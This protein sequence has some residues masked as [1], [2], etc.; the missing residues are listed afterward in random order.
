M[1]PWTP[2]LSS[3]MQPANL[4]VK[5]MNP[6]GPNPCMTRANSSVPAPTNGSVTTL[7]VPS[8]D[9]DLLTVLKPGIAPPVCSRVPLQPVAAFNDAVCDRLKSMHTTGPLTEVFDEDH[10][11]WI[12]AVV[13]DT[14]LM[15]MD[16]HGGNVVLYMCTAFRDV[17]CVMEDLA[18]AVDPPTR[19]PRGP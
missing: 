17:Q 3:V 14:D 15:S 7:P 16:E 10:R 18:W 2:R 1:G 8:A 4:T 11:K 6:R 12:D 9:L 5:R 13:Q 19:T